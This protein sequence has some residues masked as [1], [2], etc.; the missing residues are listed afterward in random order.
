MLIRDISISTATF[1]NPA[2]SELFLIHFIAS[3]A[4]GCK[5]YWDNIALNKT[6]GTPYRVEIMDRNG[7]EERLL[8]CCL[9]MKCQWTRNGYIQF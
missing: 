8:C 9:G 4:V 5:R 7:S 3:I 2:M 6:P 1:L